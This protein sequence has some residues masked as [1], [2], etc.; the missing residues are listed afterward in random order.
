MDWVYYVGIGGLIFFLALLLFADKII[1]WR[2]RKT[3]LKTMQKIY[4]RKRE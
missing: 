2:K 3:A 1:K 4:N